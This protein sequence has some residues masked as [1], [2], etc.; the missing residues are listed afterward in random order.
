MGGAVGGSV[1]IV[2]IILMVAIVSLL[3]R[4]SQGKSHK[5]ESNNNIGLLTY[6]NALYDVGKETYTC[7]AQIGSCIVPYIAWP[8]LM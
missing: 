5:V 3:V 1:V 8:I 2:V 7:N 6:N 4:K